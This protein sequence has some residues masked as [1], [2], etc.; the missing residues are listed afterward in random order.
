MTCHDFYKL[1]SEETR[2]RCLHLLLHK[3]R[4]C[5][6][7]LVSVLQMPQPN[8]SRHLSY[9]RRSKVI[10]D[11]RKGQWIYYRL[12]PKVPEYIKDVLA[13]TGEHL[14]KDPV[15]RGDLKRLRSLSELC[16]KAECS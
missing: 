2:L 6:C 9:L 10:L 8:L 16:V 3:E 14:S 11:E 4:L 5:V 15:Y 7:E 1:L 12:N 13:I